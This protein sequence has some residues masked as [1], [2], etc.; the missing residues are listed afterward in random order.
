MGFRKYLVLEEG[1]AGIAADAAPRTEV[2]EHP[3]ME[4]DER[5]A[6]RVL[7]LTLVPVAEVEGQLLDPFVSR[8]E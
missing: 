6:W 4:I 8:I 7:V 5:E 3:H 1:D 2:R